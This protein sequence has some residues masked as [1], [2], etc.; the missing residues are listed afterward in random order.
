MLIIISIIGLLGVTWCSAQPPMATL[1]LKVVDDEGN[2]VEGAE[3]MFSF[4]VIAS[5]V[6][7]LATPGVNNK[8]SITGQDGRAT[9][10]A[11]C[12]RS[13]YYGVRK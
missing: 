7:P 3:A 9:A 6:G 4:E 12:I 2:P 8:L 13:V 11:G 5:S 1:T 10:S